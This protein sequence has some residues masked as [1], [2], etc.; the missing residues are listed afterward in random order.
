[1]DYFYHLLPSEII[2]WLSAISL[3]ALLITKELVEPQVEGDGP[4]RKWMKLLNTGAIILFIIFL[5]CIIYRV[6]MIYPEYFQYS[7]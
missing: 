2:Y 7:S 3:V 5:L 6:V 1:M 4:A